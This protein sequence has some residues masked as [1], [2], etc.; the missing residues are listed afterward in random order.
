[1]NEKT[2]VGTRKGFKALDDLANAPN[3]EE[4]FYLDVCMGGVFVFINSDEL[5]E[6][7]IAWHIRHG[8]NIYG[9]MSLEEILAIKSGIVYLKIIQYEKV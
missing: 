9:C 8:I 5:R 1:M 3:K 4:L 7:Q 2:I 6:I